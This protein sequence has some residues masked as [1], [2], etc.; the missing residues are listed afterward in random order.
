MERRQ[1]HRDSLTYVFKLQEVQE[2]KKFEFVETV[3]Q[4]RTMLV[5]NY[6]NIYFY[7]LLSKT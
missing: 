5:V 6:F 3:S 1:F 7:N 4:R 2:K